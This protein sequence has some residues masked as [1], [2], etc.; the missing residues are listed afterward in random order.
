M[1]TRNYSVGADGVLLVLPPSDPTQAFLRMQVYNADGSE[2]TI[3]GNG[4]RV[5]V[6]WI[7]D[8]LLA[9]DSQKNIK[10]THGQLRFFFDPVANAAFEQGLADLRSVSG[11]SLFHLETGKGPLAVGVVAKNVYGRASQIRVDLGVPSLDPDVIPVRVRESSQQQQKPVVVLDLDFLHSSSFAS[12]S[13]IPKTVEAFKLRAVPVS[14][15]NPHCV[16]FL[17]GLDQE[18]IVCSPSN[19]MT[20]SLSTLNDFP[21]PQVAQEIQ[22]NAALFPESCNVEFVTRVSASEVH[23]RTVERGSGETLACGSGACATVVA[24]RLLGLL[25]DRVTVH[26]RGGDL[27]IEYDG[28]KDSHVFMTGPAVAVCTGYLTLENYL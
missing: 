19:E 15:G 17:D 25:G 2:S 13:N 9:V 4:I 5:V 28:R 22:S 14:M 3:C 24:G 7:H 26:L 12:R 11:P 27:L 10:P 8:R 21:A 23:Q 6:K 1:C 20:T 18:S 16:I